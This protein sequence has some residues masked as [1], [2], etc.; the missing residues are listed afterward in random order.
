MGLAE[1]ANQHAA[2]IPNKFINDNMTRKLAAFLTL[3]TPTV[4]VVKQVRE[5]KSPAA[6]IES[7]M[8]GLLVSAGLV[9]AL[10]ADAVLSDRLPL[11]LPLLDA[12]LA[13]NGLVQS[14]LV[15]YNSKVTYENNW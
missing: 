6:I 12:V 1:V 9:A 8:I 7:N 15:F 4:W 5:G 2:H 3:I 14:I 10:S 11:P 13:L